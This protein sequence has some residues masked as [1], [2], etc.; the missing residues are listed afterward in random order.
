MAK[1]WGEAT[2]WQYFSFTN[3]TR[4]YQQ[5]TGNI[6]NIYFVPA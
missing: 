2:Y 6:K 1:G 5:R 3:Q 4:Q